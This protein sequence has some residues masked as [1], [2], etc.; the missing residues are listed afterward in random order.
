MGT[1]AERILEAIKNG[2]LDD[3]AL[4]IK[5]GIS[6]RQS[7][8]QAARR[9][10]HEGRLRRHPGT[11]GKIVNALLEQPQRDGRPVASSDGRATKLTFPEDDVKRAVEAHL[12]DQGFR[13]A[14]AWGRERGV[15]I[16]A[17]HPDGRRFLIEAKSGLAS[18]Q[19]QGSYFLG[20]LGELIQRMADP[21]ARYALALPRNR[22]YR[23]LVS[24]LPGLAWQRLGLVVFWVDR[25]T[26]GVATVTVQE[27][28]GA[29]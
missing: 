23:G 7:I 9:L 1:I 19:Q 24:R 15:D 17:R 16:D 14:V 21:D 29:A 2:P 10:E 8:N 18:D 12:L 27:H 4:A 28:P 3:D 25:D 20:A 26:D 13:V 22:R 6:P 5:L 11:D